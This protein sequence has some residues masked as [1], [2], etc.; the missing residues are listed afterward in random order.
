MYFPACGLKKNSMTLFLS[1]NVN[2][3]FSWNSQKN[4]SL[5]GKSLRVGLFALSFFGI[6]DQ[7]ENSRSK[8]ETL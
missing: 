4:I 5:H 7:L 1:N 2:I 6:L 8:N 3:E